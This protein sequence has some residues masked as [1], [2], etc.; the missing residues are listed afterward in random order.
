MIVCHKPV[1]LNEVIEN[2]NADNATLMFDMNLGE[3]GHT[4][5]FLSKYPSLRVIGVD[6]DKQMIERANERLKAFGDRFS[7]VHA[8]SD[9]FLLSYKGER[10]SLIL[11]DLGLCMFHFKEANR[12][13]SFNDEKLDMRL[14]ED[15]VKNAYIVVNTYSEKEIS[16]IL[17]K[18]GGEKKSRLIARTI[19]NSRKQKRVETSK[20]L[21]DVILSCFSPKEKAVSK[22]DVA[23]RSFQAIRIEVNDEL[24]RFERALMSAYEILNVGGKIE[25][26]SFHSLEDRI[27]KWTF[28]SLNSEGKVRI[29]TKK[30]IIPSDIELEDNPASRSSKLRVVVKEK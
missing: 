17:F 26:I 2:S 20:E 1:L 29:I 8:W 19:V 18:Y 13:F 25:V 10:P 27:A 28:R 5:A 24:K 6:A 12:G 7:S 15:E 4:E 23:T 14:S 21:H 30:P 11:F 16:D 9:E 22:T 3:G